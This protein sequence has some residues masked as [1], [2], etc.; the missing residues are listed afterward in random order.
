MARDV[1]IEA[2]AFDL[3]TALL[4]S[5]S[6][7]TSVAGDEALGRTWRL[8]SLRRV[9]A[10]G[11]YRSYEE[12]LAEAAADAG[13]P[14]KK[15]DELVARWGELE[16]WPETR[17]VLQQL[18]GERLALVTNCSQRLAEIAAAATG[19]R[20]ELVMS[21]ERSGAYKA[22]PRAYQAAL[23]ALRL[24]A[25]RVLFV[26]GSAHDVPGASR[27]GMRVYWANRQRLPVPDGSPPPLFDEPDLRR[28][29]EVV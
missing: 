15:R 8:A 6:L 12:I 5:W 27:V 29:P 23:D 4:D 3:L 9:T 18:S 28:L 25:D 20:F 19:G 26:A 21:A 17:S 13:V 14:V 11:S 7:Y 2:V 22:A 24:P 1:R 10:Q 16:P